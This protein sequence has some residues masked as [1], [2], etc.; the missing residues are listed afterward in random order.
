METLNFIGVKEFRE[1]GYL[2][3]LNRQFLHPLGLALSIEINS[4]GT[5]NLGGIWDY[6]EDPEGM[7]YGNAIT[8][9]EKF[10]ENIKRIEALQQNAFHNRVELLGYMYQEPTELPE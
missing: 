4:D 5:E 10:K 2:Q 7:K 9:S 3:E 8:C 1:Q 6:R